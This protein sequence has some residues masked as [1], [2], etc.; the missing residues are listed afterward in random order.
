M[1]TSEIM[2]LFGSTKNKITKEG[3]GENMPRLETNNSIVILSTIIVNIIQESFMNL[4][5][6]NGL[7]N[8]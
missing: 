2:K 4:L 1:L 6:T 8:Y 5:L 7:A 3:N